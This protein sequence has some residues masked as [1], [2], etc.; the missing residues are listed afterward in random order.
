MVLDEP[1]PSEARRAAASC[2]RRAGLGEGD[3]ANLEVTISELVT[4]AM[5]HGSPPHVV[6]LWVEPGR[7]VTAVSDAGPG[8]PDPCAGL[9]KGDRPDGG[10]G[11]WIA[12]QVCTDVV[13]E[14]HDAGFTARASIGRLPG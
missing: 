7:V 2:G 3:L 1:A 8:I 5:L 10:L 11:L 14:R 9:L 13:L 12:H 6:E 4:N